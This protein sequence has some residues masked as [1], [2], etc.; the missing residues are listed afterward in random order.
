M[1]S[2]MKMMMMIMMMM[3]I[4]MMMMV[5]TLV[6]NEQEPPAS[7]MRLHTI[8]DREEGWVQLVEALVE[9]IPLA[10]P[11]GPA[12]MTLLLDDCPLP[13][14]GAFILILISLPSA[15]YILLNDSIM[16]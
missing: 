15:E 8:A 5:R 10:D 13:T 14:V 3:T 4:M 7:L 9:V 11:L 1:R 12:V 16:Q 6:E 2:G